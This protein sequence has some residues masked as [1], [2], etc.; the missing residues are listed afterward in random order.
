MVRAVVT[1]LHTSSKILSFENLCF[2][3]TVKFEHLCDLLYSN[4]ESAFYPF[5]NGKMSITCW[6]LSY[7]NL[8]S[9]PGPVNESY[10]L[11]TTET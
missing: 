10:S 8:L 3:P 9:H 2:D 11:I 4:I 6:G 7:N 5:R 1:S